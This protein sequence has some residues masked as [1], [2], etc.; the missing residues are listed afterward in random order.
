[1]VRACTPVNIKSSKAPGR[2][3][4]REVSGPSALTSEPTSEKHA[5]TLCRLAAEQGKTP[6][7]GPSQSAQQ[8]QPVLSFPT[9][10]GFHIHTH[11]RTRQKKKRPCHRC[12]DTPCQDPHPCMNPPYCTLSSKKERK[13]KGPHLSV[14]RRGTL[15]LSPA[16]QRAPNIVFVG[17]NAFHSVFRLCLFTLHEPEPRAVYYCIYSIFEGGT[18]PSILQKGNNTAIPGPECTPVVQRKFSAALEISRIHGRVCCMGISSVNERSPCLLYEFMIISPLKGNPLASA[19]T[20]LPGW[21]CPV[22]APGQA[23]RAGR[24]RRLRPSTVTAKSHFL[25][26]RAGRHHLASP[27]LPSAQRL[28]IE[29]PQAGCAGQTSFTATRWAA[30]CLRARVIAA[31]PRLYLGRA[32]WPTECMGF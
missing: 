10:Q 16:G 14:G 23:G 20:R 1:M 13:K 2:I 8:A 11:A 30:M 32:G 9:L 21:L 15:L 25:A 27:P 18:N 22:Q 7:P 26:R 28:E 5:R 24:L 6:F 17:P 29:L 12:H 19:H 3:H 4:S 31:A